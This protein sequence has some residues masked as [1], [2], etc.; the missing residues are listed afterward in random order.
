MAGAAGA[1]LCF[2]ASMP[3][4]TVDDV[5]ALPRLPVPGEGT[6]SYL[7]ERKG[8]GG[9]DGYLTMTRGAL[10]AR[11][12]FWSAMVAARPLTTDSGS[13]PAKD[14]FIGVDIGPDGTAWGAFYQD[15]PPSASDPVCSQGQGAN[16]EADRGFA[17]SLSWP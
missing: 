5:T 14:Y 15:C 8:G 13:T 16:F 3:A 10:A 1:F 2:R 7:G 12:V 17:A 9:Y 11:S 4:I 6:I